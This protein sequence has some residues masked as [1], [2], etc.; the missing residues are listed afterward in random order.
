MP[1]G[2]R[3]RR[4]FHWMS[5]FATAGGGAT[6]G[7]RLSIILRNKS[8]PVG[9]PTGEPADRPC[10]QPF[11]CGCT[12]ND[13]ATH[14]HPPFR[15]RLPPVSRRHTGFSSADAC[16]MAGSWRQPFNLSSVRR[17]SACAIGSLYALCSSGFAPCKTRS[18][19]CDAMSSSSV[20]PSKKALA[21][22]A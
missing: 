14:A 4:I 6:G 5:D 15:R 7:V 3:R 21:A 17:I 11:A 12:R 8:V 22:S 1:H 10:P 16:K 9:R 18:A 2:R 19:A 20:L 13:K